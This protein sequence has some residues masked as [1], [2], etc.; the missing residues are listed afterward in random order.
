MRLQII[1]IIYLLFFVFNIIFPN[2]NTLQH[3]FSSCLFSFEAIG[4]PGT[5]AF[6][7]D[8]IANLIA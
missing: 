2:Q 1:M 4:F 8:V 6:P 7:L 5:L 3:G